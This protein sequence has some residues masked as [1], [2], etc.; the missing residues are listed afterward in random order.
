ME[1]TD[2]HAQIP[3][4]QH[5]PTHNTSRYNRRTNNPIHKKATVV[6]LT[7]STR[8]ITP[9]ITTRRALA[10]KTLNRLQRFRNISTNNER[11][12]YKTIIRPQLL[13]PIIPLNTISHSSY[14]KLQQVQNKALRF[15]E[16]TKLTDRIPS[17]TLHTR[18]EL[19][20]INT[21]P[22]TSNRCMEA[23]AWQ[24]PRPIWHPEAG[25]R[26]TYKTHE[27][28]DII[29]HC[30]IPR[31]PTNIRLTNNSLTINE[32]LIGPPFLEL[33]ARVFFLGRW[34]YLGWPT[35]HCPLDIF[36]MCYCSTINDSLLD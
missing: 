10:M 30:G 24:K 19:P 32:S 28:P 29:S 20:A 27:L 25:S 33:R 34:V 18:N 35:P 21:Y 17:T 9:Q 22:Q 12:L 7:F 36:I 15:I 26:R 6:G 1:N 8:S 16:N 4:T 13:Y 14:R 5:S 2:E 23:T 31:T 3:N 11:R